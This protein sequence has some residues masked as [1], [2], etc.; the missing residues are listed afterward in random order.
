MKR[1]AIIFL[2]AT[3]AIITIKAQDEK[4]PQWEYDIKLGFN[5]GGNSPLPLP[6]EIRKI[7]SYSPTFAP[8]IQIGATRWFN[9]KWGLTSGI[10]LEKKGMS[11]Q[12]K[13]KNYKTEIVE[14]GNKLKGNW[15]G[16][17]KTKVTSCNLTIP[18]LCTYRANE[19][20]NIKAG[21]FLSYLIDGEMNGYVN[22]GYLRKNDPTGDKVVFDDK[23]KGT[24]DFSDEMRKLIFGLQAGAEYSFAEKF[25][26]YA[27]LTWGVND[28]M[29][30]DFKTITFSMYPIYMNIGLGY[31]L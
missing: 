31:T 25:K 24:Y 3:T 11:T 7:K 28:T 2:L 26:L 13:V 20:I 16:N 27:D 12:A 9:S 18:L 30:D 1:F 4:H 6:V 10:K 21:A 23:T 19:K 14:N 22:D 8:S 5:V 29:K 17:V 15:T